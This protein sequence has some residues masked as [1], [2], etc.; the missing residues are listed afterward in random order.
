[1]KEVTSWLESG[2]AYTPHSEPVRWLKLLLDYETSIGYEKL[3]ESK[4]CPNKN[5]TIET[6][7]NILRDLLTERK[8][9]KVIL[10]SAQ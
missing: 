6:L 2:E 9:C 10:G 1:V 7:V 8:S 5:A 4:V 3:L